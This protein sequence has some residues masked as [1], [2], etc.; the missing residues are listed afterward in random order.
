MTMVTSNDKSIGGH[1]KHRPPKDCY[2]TV[3]QPT[4]KT[5]FT[6][7][8][9]LLELKFTKIITCSVANLKVFDVWSRL[10]SK[11]FPSFKVTLNSKK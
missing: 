3:R 11:Y 8:D 6:Y 9:I 4:A 1:R 7:L 10:E 2:L 5:P